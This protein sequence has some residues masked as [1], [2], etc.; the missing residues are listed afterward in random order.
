[1]GAQLKGPLVNYGID[2]SIDVHRV[3]VQAEHDQTF[4]GMLE[5]VAIV[6][7]QGGRIIN[8][9]DWPLQLTFSA[10]E[11]ES[12]KR[13]GLTLHQEI[14]SPDGPVYLRLAV[15]D[16]MTAHLGSLEIAVTGPARPM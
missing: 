9:V 12:L 4:H 16:L 5:L 8:V 7:D 2:Y 14:S 3:S 6:Y 11:Y 15:Y 1:M 10:A 13:T